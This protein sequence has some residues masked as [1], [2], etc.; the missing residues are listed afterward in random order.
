MENF[1][2]FLRIPSISPPEADCVR[3]PGVAA[4]AAVR[5]VEERKRR[6]LV[7]PGS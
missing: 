3:I 7:M 4:A 6:R 5:A 1:T 2:P